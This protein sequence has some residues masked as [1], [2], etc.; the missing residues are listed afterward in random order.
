MLRSEMWKNTKMFQNIDKTES[1]LNYYKRMNASNEVLKLVGLESKRFGT[2]SEKIIS[3]VLGLGERTSSQND[4]TYN[5]KKIEIKCARYWAGK[6]ECKWQHLEP[7]HDYEYAIFGLLDF[8]EFKIWI[9]KKSLLMGELREKNIVTFQGKQG[10]WTTKS[11]VI[12][13]LTPIESVEELSKF[14]ENQITK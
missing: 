9:I 5:G 10:W 14:M 3:E 6:D 12:P 13:Y 8:H 11:G 2:V 4:A 7:D 1:Q